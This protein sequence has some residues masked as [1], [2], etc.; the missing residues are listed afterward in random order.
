MKLKNLLVAASFGATLTIGSAFTLDAVGYEGGV[1]ESNP[2]SIFVPGYGELVFEAVNGSSL[3]VNSAYQNDNGFG[4]PSLSFDENEVVKVTFNGDEPLNVDFDF[5]G[6][7]AG[8]S[9]VIEKDLFTPQAFLVTLRGQGD[10][11]GLYAMSWN[12]VPEPSSAALG[13]LGATMLAFRRRR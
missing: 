9:F 1:L 4:G 3:V 5:V 2:F 13:I 7:S 11:A 6:Q 8:E 12:T 10:G